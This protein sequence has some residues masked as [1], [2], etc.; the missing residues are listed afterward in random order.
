[1]SLIE[2]PRTREDVVI[3]ALVAVKSAKQRGTPFRIE[4]EAVRIRRKYPDCPVSLDELVA[5][6]ARLCVWERVPLRFK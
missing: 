5:T 6:M 3:E 1:M 2:R 4:N